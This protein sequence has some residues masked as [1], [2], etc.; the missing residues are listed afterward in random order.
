MSNENNSSHLESN[1]G[2]STI[3]ELSK[4]TPA[5]TSKSKK[6]MPSKKATLQSKKTIQK[7]KKSKS[8]R[9]ESYSLFIFRVLKQVHPEL[10]ISS[11]SMSIMNSF[12]EDLFDRITD[13]A[14]K[15]SNLGGKGKTISNRE[16]QSAVRLVL[17]G[18][19]AR[20]AISE[21]TKALHKFSNS[22]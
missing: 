11:K 5:T 16:I 9:K 12:V 17:P 13:E 22:K 2:E 4:S 19:L 8:K 20:H 14:A 1:Q 15:L 3:I 10:S 18:E 21:G 7:K 6:P